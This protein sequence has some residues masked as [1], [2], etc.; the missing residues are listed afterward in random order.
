MACR[1]PRIAAA[2]GQ[3]SWPGSAATAKPPTPG[4][5]EALALHEQA[6][7]PV[8]QAETLHPAPRELTAQ[9]GRVAHLA[10]TGASNPQ[11]A[12]QLPVTVSTVETHLERI[13]AKLGIRS[14]HELIARAVEARRDPKN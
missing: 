9:E 1:F 3:A 7:L 2:A 12:R 8:E 14:R 4:F 5:G 13:Y 6:D 10:A 11:I